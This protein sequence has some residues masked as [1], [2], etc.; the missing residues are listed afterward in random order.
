MKTMTA[1]PEHPI[2]LAQKLKNHQK[3]QRNKSQSHDIYPDTTSKNVNDTNRR[4]RHLTTEE[5]TDTKQQKSWLQKLPTLI[6]MAGTSAI[7]FAL[8]S[9]LLEGWKDSSDFSI[10]LIFLVHTGALTVLALGIGHFFKEGK[11]ARSLLMLSLIATTINF[12]ILGGLIFSTALPDGLIQYPELVRWTA[13]SLSEA[14]LLTATGI[15]I[16]L[17]AVVVGFRVLS[18][19]M[20]KRVSI[21][22]LLSNLCLLIPLR[23]PIS[24]SLMALALV[25]ITI[26]FNHKNTRQRTEAKTFEGRFSLLIQYFPAMVLIGRNFFLY[27][28]ESLLIFTFCITLFIA[29]RQISIA[30]KSE[31]WIRATLECLSPILA[32]MSGI[33][34]SD[35]LDRSELFDDM[36]Y[37]I[38]CILA[39][40]MI[41]EISTRSQ[42]YAKHFRVIAMSSLTIGLGI[43]VLLNLSTTATLSIFIIAACLTVYGYINQQKSIFFAAVTLLAITLVS[44]GIH[45][46]QFFEINYWTLGVLGMIAIFASSALEARGTIITSR[47]KRLTRDFA[48]W[49]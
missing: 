39:S 11:G 27:A 1:P 49:S 7:L 36:A 15:V 34:I 47:I 35:I 8:Y 48:N 37:V 13:N 6:R 18:R 44:Q 41:Y 23:A 28:Q 42:M 29:L 10:F 31:S 32:Y 45:L 3:I 21:L 46:F 22:F 24:I 25:S 2:A 14:L 33:L 30:L 5:Q 20:S 26:M 40:L 16:L 17:P 38:G 12:S 4:S 9:F 43:L 19:G